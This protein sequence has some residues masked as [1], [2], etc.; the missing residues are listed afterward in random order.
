MSTHAKLK[1]N[2]ATV[3]EV[4]AANPYLTHGWLRHQLFNRH[5]NGL[6]RCV[7]PIGRKL[8]IDVDLFQEWME[9]G[10]GKAEPPRRDY[11]YSVRR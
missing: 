9:Q 3:K 1:R 6:D 2:L 8:L 10:C 4:L 11:R 5:E 7:F